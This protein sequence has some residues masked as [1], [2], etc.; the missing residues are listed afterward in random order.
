MAYMISTLFKEGTLVDIIPA[1]CLSN[2]NAYIHSIKLLR[3][4]K[5]AS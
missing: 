2:C 3:T 5:P 4:A 1:R